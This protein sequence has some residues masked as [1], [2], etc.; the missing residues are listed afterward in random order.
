[1]GKSRKKFSCKPHNL[2]QSYAVQPNE[3]NF[4]IAQ[5][6]S[7]TLHIFL[8]HQVTGGPLRGS[9]FSAVTPRETGL[10]TRK[11]AGSHNNLVPQVFPV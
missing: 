4:M 5:I 9:H 10:S 3:L 8:H 7:R 11:C 2:D 6:R 1:M